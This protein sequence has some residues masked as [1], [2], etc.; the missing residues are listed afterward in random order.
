MTEAV[1]LRVKRHKKVVLISSIIE[2]YSNA[3]CGTP[4]AEGDSVVPKQTQDALVGT[5][6]SE[7]STAH[8]QAKVHVL[9]IVKDQFFKP[10]SVRRQSGKKIRQES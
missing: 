7:Q 1:L 6:W 3:Y 2:I 4:T 10:H 9:F 5:R 8:I